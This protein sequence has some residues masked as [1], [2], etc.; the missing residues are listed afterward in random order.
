MPHDGREY[1]VTVPDAVTVRA[2]DG[3]YVNNCN[4]SAFISNLPTPPG[5]EKSVDSRHF[6]T[7]EAS[8]STSQ[9]ANV[10]EAIEMG[11]KAL[12][13][14]EDVSAANFM[15]RDGRM[16]SLVMDE[17]ITPLLYRVNGLYKTHGISTIVVVGGVG[18]WLDVPDQVILMDKYMAQD[19]TKKARSISYQFSYGHVQYA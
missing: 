4:I 15:A 14:D 7:F 18:D 13:V 2:E 5:V 6:S 8:G 9:A 10:S 16:R 1:C 19:A 17:S 12:L 11:A 3:R